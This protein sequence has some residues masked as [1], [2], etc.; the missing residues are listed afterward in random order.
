MEGVELHKFLFDWLERSLGKDGFNQFCEEFSLDPVSIRFSHHEYGA[1]RGNSFHVGS[2]SHGRNTPREPA[3]KRDSKGNRGGK[4]KGGGGQDYGKAGKGK[5][6]GGK[7][8]GNQQGNGNEKGKGGNRQN[9]KRNNSKGNSKGESSASATHGKGSA[10][11]P[12]EPSKPKEA[13]KVLTEQPTGGENSSM[14]RPRGDSAAPG[15]SK[16]TSS[17]VPY[18]PLTNMAKTD[19]TSFLG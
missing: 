13:T 11:P 3:P 8:K 6:G 19:I 1:N 4:G 10:K 16:G 2:Q 7:S 9:N 12:T 15:A 18:R 14:W 5:G 17:G